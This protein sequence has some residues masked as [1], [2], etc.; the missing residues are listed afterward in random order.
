MERMFCGC[1]PGAIFGRLW[2]TFGQ[3]EANNGLESFPA[4]ASCR[5]F[6]LQMT[7]PDSLGA[8]CRLLRS[9]CRD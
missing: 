2:A 9:P 8:A 3:R 7:L 6:R 1:R 4:V 5:R